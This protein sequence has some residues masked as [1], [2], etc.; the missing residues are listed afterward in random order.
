MQDKISFIVP[1]K[2]DNKLRL[3]NL[4]A[5]SHFYFKYLPQAEYVYIEERDKNAEYTFSDF[6]PKDKK[7]KHIVHEVKSSEPI[8]KTA[9]YNEGAK[10]AKNDIFV[11]I[12][13]DIIV[14]TEKLVSEIED[15]VNKRELGVHVGYTGVSLYMTQKGEQD[16]L[17]TY[18]IDDLFLKWKNKFNLTMGLQ[19]E[20]FTCMNINSV[21]GCLVMSRQT[22]NNINGF[23]PNY[24][25]WGYE[26]NEVVIRA[27]NLKQNVTKS[28]DLD[29]VLY[30]LPHN[31]DNKNPSMHK[32]YEKNQAESAKV[33]PMPY[34]QLKEYIKTW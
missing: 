24:K 18:N 20:D 7:Y 9:N 27:H 14:N 16:F 1:V 11:F 15:L 13:L 6:L 26:D 34:E 2:I 22:F 21:G 5:I 23:N 30:H 19:T 4:K 31:V 28:N 12:D 29:N 32:F 33:D 17:N 10:K 8:H 25:G 3:K